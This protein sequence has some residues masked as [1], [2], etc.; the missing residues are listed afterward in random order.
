MLDP[1]SQR[2]PYLYGSSQNAYR[3]GMEVDQP[4]YLFGLGLMDMIAYVWGDTVSI[5]YICSDMYRQLNMAVFSFN[6]SLNKLVENLLRSVCTWIKKT[7][8]GREVYMHECA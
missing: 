2:I 6:A 8:L 7:K 5:A 3:N 1:N 4:P